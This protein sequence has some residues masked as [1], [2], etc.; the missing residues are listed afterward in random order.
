MKNFLSYAIIAGNI[1]TFNEAAFSMDEGDTP[2]KKVLFR[3]SQLFQKAKDYIVTGKQI[4]KILNNIDGEI[5]DNEENSTAV[6]DRYEPGED[7]FP[8]GVYALNLDPTKFSDLKEYTFKWLPNLPEAEPADGVRL[9]C[10]SETE[11][12]G[13]SYLSGKWL[14]VGFDEDGKPFALA[15][16][17]EY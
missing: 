9:S 10:S 14:C 17:P 12:A 2:P 8:I 4:K 15:L 1:I 16:D 13:E 3:K 6:F 7:R 11:P 5:G